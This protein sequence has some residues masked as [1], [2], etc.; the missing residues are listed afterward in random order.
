VNGGPDVAA[1]AALLAE[2]TRVAVVLAV[3]DDGALPATELAARAGIARSTA[4]EHLGRLV[5]GGLLAV[6]TNGRHR[7]YDLADPAVARAV[8]AL[9][10][11]APQR[12][13]R[14]LREATASE[15][16]RLA[17]TCYDHL[18]GRLGVA[19]TRALELQGVLVRR[20]DALALG[21]RARPRLDELEIDLDALARRRR[22]LVRG[23][24]D[25][26]ERELH[27]AGALGAAIA[28][29]LFELGWIE[30]RDAN[31]SVAVTEVGRALFTSRLGVDLDGI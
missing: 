10:A 19:L 1:A 9:A 15:M 27:V 26:S 23:C 28:A 3:M 2:P 22:P 30:R 31:R 21:R 6:V 7:Y 12:P 29:R 25:W 14:S 16:I 11:V 17:R 18:A 13:V 4:S 20:G 5:D 24:L 8:E